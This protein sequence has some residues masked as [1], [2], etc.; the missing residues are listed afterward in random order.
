MSSAAAFPVTVRIDISKPVGVL[1]PIWRFFGADEPNYATEAQGKALLTELGGLRPGQI[2]FRAHN[3]MTS[4]DGTPDF[5]WGSTN[6]YTLQGAS[7]ST[8]SPSP[9]TSSTPTWRAVS[10]RIWR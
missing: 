6:L 1:Q 4:G 8:T 3:L 5:K 2:Y 9:I 10:I 7:R